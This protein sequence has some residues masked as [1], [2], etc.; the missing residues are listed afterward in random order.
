MIITCV[1]SCK[2]ESKIRVLSPIISTRSHMPSNSLGGPFFL[3]SLSFYPL[4]MVYFR[5]MFKKTTSMVVFLFFSNV[6][7][8]QFFVLS[9]RFSVHACLVWSKFWKQFFCFQKQEKHFKIADD[10]LLHGKWEL[11]IWW[12]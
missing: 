1:H 2:Q 10:D 11:M 9:Y 8:A 3:F 5:S 12:L 7:S 4:N 6:N